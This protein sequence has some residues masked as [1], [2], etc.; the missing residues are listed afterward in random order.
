M[1]YINKIQENLTESDRRRLA[2]IFAPTIVATQPDDSRRGLCVMPDGEIR[3]YGIEG[4]THCWHKD[5]I[6]VYLASRNGL[7][8]SRHE[9]PEGSAPV[10]SCGMVQTG[11]IAMGAA[12]RAP[13][14]GRYVTVV[15]IGEGEMRGTWAELSD[16]GPGDTSPRMVKITDEVCGDLFQPVALTTMHR[17]LVTTYV[18]K[19]GNYF[20]RVLITDDDGETWHTVL[21]KPTPKH[22]AVFPHRGVRWQNN[23]SEPNLCELPDGRLM[24]LARTSLDYFYVYYSSDHGESWTDGEPSCFHG[25]LTT[26]FLLRLSDGRVICFWNNNRPLAEQNH[27]RTWPP[28]SNGTKNGFGEDAFTNRDVNHAAITSD[29]IHW[30]GFRE[31]ALDEVRGASDFRVKGG[32]ATSADKSVHQFQALELPDG[33]ILI[34]YGQ[35]SI[36]RRMAIFDVN[37]LY[38]KER[39]EDFQLGLE[40]ITT[41][42]FVKSLCESHIG[43]GFNGHCAWNRTD[44]ALL[45]PDPDCTGGEALQICRVH[46]A[47]LVSELQGAVWNF[48]AADAGEIRLT[49]RVEGAGIRVRLCDHW[50]NAC[51]EYVGLYACYDFELD[52]RELEPG[53]WHEVTIAFGDGC[54]AVSAS[55]KCLYTVPMKNPAPTGI[56][57]LHMQTMAEGTDFDGTL[58]RRM[59][60]KAK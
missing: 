4:K 26:P 52:A 57:Y 43:K 51:D 40:H 1:W 20:P 50:M 11:T 21:I 19:D 23:G 3:Y 46:D 32:S 59:E 7:D 24:L 25:T 5:G 28:I 13:W 38:E 2:R 8:W 35:N 30:T 58:I 41:H 36:T 44:G 55:G 9:G 34:A 15:T 12:A 6:S 18:T 53:M 47:R 33:K 49:M 42:L 39:V 45:V 16:I 31:I 48:P 14:S 22:T 17:M 56:S 29:G 27:D 60:F 10:N 54:A 37:W